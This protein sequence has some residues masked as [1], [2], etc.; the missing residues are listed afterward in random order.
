MKI[1]AIYLI[2]LVSIIS[3]KNNNSD[4]S[5]KDSIISTDSNKAIPKETIVDD[6]YY[7]YFYNFIRDFSNLPEFQTNSI[8][9][10]IEFIHNNKDTVILEEKNWIFINIILD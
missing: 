8:I 2:L 5:K 7:G 6:D 9:F 1:K 3:C 10:P 4:L